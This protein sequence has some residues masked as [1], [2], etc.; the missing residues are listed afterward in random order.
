MNEIFIFLSII[1]FL[2]ICSGFFSSSETALT[3]VSEARINELVTQGSKRAKLIEKILKNREKMISTILIGNNLVNVVASVYATSFAIMYFNDAKL[4]LVTLI[5]TIILVVFAEVIPKTYALKNADQIALSVAP[6]INL[7]MMILTPATLFT[8]QLARLVTGPVV[9]DE[10]AK[11]EELKGM[12]RL[13]AGEKSRAIER[14][15]MMSS[16]LDMEEVSIE[17]V[18]THRGTVTMIDE[19]S[20][21]NEIFKVTGDSPFTRIPVYSGTKDNIIGIL[22]AKE[23]FRYLQRSRFENINKINLSEIM[24]EPYFAPETTLILDQLEVFRGR[25]EH[26]AIVVNEYGDFRGIVTL[27]D[28]LEEIVGDID[29]ETDIDVEGVKSQP[30]GSLIVEGSVTIRDLNRSLGWNLPDEKYN[31]IAGLVLFESKTIPDPGQ[32]FRFFNVKFR[33]LQ[34][35]SNFISKLRIWNEIGNLNEKK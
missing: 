19:K 18:M 8:E 16:M 4:A 14:G 25:K 27:E 21:A 33:I 28:I 26:F 17:A 22:H 29:D 23:L 35:K 2:I 5:L 1:I 31:T 32:E 9:D 34:K 12:I 3:A 24:I 30:D 7:L 11:T 15:K 20:T 6:I 13:H 10:E